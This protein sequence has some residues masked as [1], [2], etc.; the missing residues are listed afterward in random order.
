M[1]DSWQ[2]VVLRATQ[3]KCIRFLEASSFP[4]IGRVTAVR[5]NLPDTFQDDVSAM[6][7]AQMI[8]IE[9]EEVAF[10]TQARNAAQQN[11]AA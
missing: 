6:V 8:G 9:G 7:R 10:M 2:E 11:L 1:L 3:E 4:P 5:V